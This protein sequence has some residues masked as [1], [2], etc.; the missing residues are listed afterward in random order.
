MVTAQTLPNLQNGNVWSKEWNKDEH[1]HQ[2]QGKDH[3]LL[4]TKYVA[5]EAIRY[6]TE[7]RTYGRS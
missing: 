5:K 2:C 3:G 7:Y 4:I 6:E 1:G